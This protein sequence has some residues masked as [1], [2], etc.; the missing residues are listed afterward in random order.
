MMKFPDGIG[1]N[2]MPI[3]GITHNSP[4]FGCV[5]AAWNESGRGERRIVVFAAIDGIV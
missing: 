4:G 5:T 2:F 1:I 3:I